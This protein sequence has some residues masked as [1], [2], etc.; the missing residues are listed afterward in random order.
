MDWSTVQL[1]HVALHL[2]SGHSMSNY[3]ASYAFPIRSLQQKLNFRK[4]TRK[5]R[6]PRKTNVT[7]LLLAE[8]TL[9]DCSFHLHSQEYHGNCL[10]DAHT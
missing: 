7:F 3:C 2:K 8:G 4:H 10:F 6:Q 5:L 9:H 1:F